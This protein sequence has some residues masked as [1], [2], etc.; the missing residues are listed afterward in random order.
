MKL[1]KRQLR[2]IIKEERAK[3][4]KEVDHGGGWDG[5]FGGTNSGNEFM[6]FL[7]GALQDAGCTLDPETWSYIREG[8]TNIEDEAYQFELDN[9]KYQDAADL[10]G[11]YMGTYGLSSMAF[12]LLLTLYTSKKRIN[13]KM[14]HMMSLLLGGIGF[15]IMRFI[16]NPN[17]L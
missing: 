12:A 9:K 17:W 7:S 3:L 11:S 10:V 1:T 4:L 6:H 14:T 16:D 5:N 2:R 8:I 13:R 15:I